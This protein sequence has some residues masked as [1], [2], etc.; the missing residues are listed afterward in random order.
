VELLTS[1]RF[2]RRTFIVI[3]LLSVLLLY[4]LPDHAG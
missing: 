3:T 1:G 4:L 2:S